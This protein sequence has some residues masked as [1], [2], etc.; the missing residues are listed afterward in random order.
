[1]WVEELSLWTLDEKSEWKES[2]EE[3]KQKIKE[4]SK[5]STQVRKKIKDSQIKWKEIANFLARILWRYYNN[6]NIINIIHNFLKHIQQE[7]KNLIVIFSPFLDKDN[8]FTKINDYILYIKENIKKI[9]ENHIELIISII[10]F[11]KLWWEM[12]WK[13]L[14]KEDSDIGYEK[15]IRELKKELK[16][17]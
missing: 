3:E 10:E 9:N 6:W 17:K 4:D 8:K 7:Q 11:E 16:S 15:F 14:K 1:M 2:S 12:F 5:K 13:T